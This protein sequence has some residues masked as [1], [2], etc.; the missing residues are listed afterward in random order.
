MKA[1]LSERG[2]YIVFEGLQKCGKSTQVKLLAEYLAEKFPERR[3]V[4]TRE[5]GGTPL[6][7][8][9]RKIA[10][11]LT[12]AQEMDPV[13][14]AYLYA[15][16]RAQSLRVIVGPALEQGAIVLADR[17]KYSS[18]AIQGVARGLGVE[19]VRDVNRVAVRGFRPDK[20]YFIDTPPEICEKR[21]RDG[22]DI[23]DKFETMRLEFFRAIRE[24]YLALAYEDGFETIPGDGSIEQIHASIVTSVL[25][26][27]HDHS[28]N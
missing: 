5:P 17:S 7:E 6:A 20:V 13:C 24:G 4:V 11:G 23:G 27:L 12:H 22:L 26:L 28:E 10:Q 9:I 16:A 1:A 15:A 21:A 25:R 3:V 14:E 8:A 18:E 2:V 19:T